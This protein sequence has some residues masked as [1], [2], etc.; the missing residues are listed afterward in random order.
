MKD[1]GDW[2][3]FLHFLR[4][5]ADAVEKEMGK[6]DQK[7]KN[8]EKPKAASRLSDSPSMSSEENGWSPVPAEDQGASNQNIENMMNQMV[9]VMNN[10]SERLANLEVAQQQ[11]RGMIVPG[12]PNQPQ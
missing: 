12:Y 1:E 4:L 11:H 5:K 2:K 7:K 3:P 9:Q 10:L 8:K 6:E